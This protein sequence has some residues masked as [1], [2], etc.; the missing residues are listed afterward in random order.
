VYLLKKRKNSKSIRHGSK[1]SADS[2]ILLR[3]VFLLLIEYG[4]GK[5]FTARLVFS[6]ER[7]TIEKYG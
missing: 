7:A 4:S 1:Y 5:T 6:N 3:T 2:K